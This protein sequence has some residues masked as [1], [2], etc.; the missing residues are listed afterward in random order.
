MK[1]NETN[2]ENA[3]VLRRLVIAHLCTSRVHVAHSSS[4]A[5]PKRI[6]RIGMKPK[7]LIGISF[8]KIEQFFCFAAVFLFFMPG[9]TVAAEIEVV[10][11]SVLSVK[12]KVYYASDAKCL[13]VFW[14]AIMPN[15]I[16]CQFDWFGGKISAKINDREDLKNAD[17]EIKN[18]LFLALVY[19]EA[20]RLRLFVPTSDQFLEALRLISINTEDIKKCQLLRA[21]FFGEKKDSNKE[22][23]KIVFEI[24]DHIL[25]A[26]TYLRVHGSFEKNLQLLETHW[27]WH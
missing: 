9:P 24:V 13:C 27:Y 1:T 5:L 11:R 6:L 12:S 18:F 8:K 10:D 3:S 20:T 16:S 25:R 19:A 21:N 4:P 26:K 14:N 2:P 23:D 17:R 7:F 15:K 22:E